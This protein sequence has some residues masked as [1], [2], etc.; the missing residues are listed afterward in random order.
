MPSVAMRRTRVFGVVKAAD[1]A[2]VLRSGRRLWPNSVEPKVKLAHDVDGH[3]WDSLLKDHGKNK[4]N[5]TSVSSSTTGKKYDFRVKRRRQTKTETAH[6]EKPVDKVF[7]IV[8]SR[9][10]K[11]LCDRASDSADKSDETMSNLK[12]YCGRRGVPDQVSCCQPLLTLAADWSCGNCW[13]SSVFGLVMRYMRREKLRLSAL[14]AFFLSHPIND[15]YADHGIQFLLEPPNSPHGNCKFFGVVDSLPLFS[16]DF[17]A[18]PPCFMDMHITLLLRVV[19]R[20][21]IFVKKSI[22][23][24]KN[25]GSQAV[26]ESNTDT[27]EFIT[28]VCNSRDESVLSLL[29]SMRASK[30]TGGN[31]QYRGSLGSHGFQKRRSSFRR[32]RARNLSHGVHKSYI[33]ISISE[34]TGSRK[35]QAAFSSTASPRNLRSSMLH[36]SAP[37]SNEISSP[38]AI[39][40]QE[41]DSL[42]CSANILVTDSDRC[43]REGG[44]D[45]LLEFSS[46]SREW[47]IVFKKDGSI[48]YSHKAQKMMRPC[49][50]NR[51][52][53]SIT[54]TGDDNLK[55]E[56][57][58]RQDWL[59]FKDMYK[60]CYE[61]NVLEPNIKVIPIPGV[62]EVMGFEEDINSHH[63]CF[64]S[65]PVSYIAMKE[66]EVSRAL[67][68]SSAV[69]D[70]D[71]ED[72]EWL[73]R[74]NREMPGGVETSHQ[75]QLDSFETMIDGF[76]KA[77]FLS[78]DDDLSDEKAT[79][80][81]LCYLG[82]QE[83]LEAVYGYWTRKRKQRKAPLIGVFQGQQA[84]NAPLL[85]KPVFR[86]RRSFKRQGSQLHVKAKEPSPLQ[87]KATE[88]NVSEEQ[89]ALGR[90]EEA[91]VSAD[92]S[93]EIA[94]TKRQI[95]QVLAENADLIVYKAMVA[96]RIAEAI[97]AA[98]TSESATTLFLN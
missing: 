55:L 16:V 29:T 18:V 7:G 57:C 22:F 82:K 74:Y 68:R 37:R 91:K 27:E 36:N 65:R 79:I 77:C 38:H 75:L 59:A 44:F 50:C 10:R 35:N 41:C 62:R 69:Y 24:I 64:F 73:K 49:S 3:G 78:P 51:F 48:R 56:F 43:M 97:R 13:F 98:E 26:E 94:I 72:E 11:R 61:R 92:T 95:A 28:Q 1:G 70:M 52:T 54:W 42:C 53:H 85:S 6:D 40:G 71:S 87:E 23:F 4:A 31:A 17:A 34:L 88:Q 14:Y 19:C 81:S 84:K 47:Y 60:D 67:A 86:K 93:M 33:G 66:D 96:L 83:V 80:T 2:R 45:V 76:E 89:S 9:K 25:G 30:L 5:K 90:V 8:Y 58:D 21:F 39:T 46:S 12:F 63:H 32:R 20:S 15:V